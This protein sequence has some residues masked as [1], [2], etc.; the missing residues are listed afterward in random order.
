MAGETLSIVIPAWKST[1][2]EASLKSLATQ[3]DLRFRVYVGDDAGSVDIKHIAERFSGQLDLM[4]H[5]YEERLGASSLVQQW[6]R[7]VRLSGESWVWLF[8]DDDVADPHCVARFFEVL[9]ETQASYDVYRFNSV[10]IDDNGH[11]TAVHPPHP[12]EESAPEFLYHTLTNQRTSPAPE[13]IFS[14]RIFDANEGFVDFPLAWS[15]D[16]ASYAKFSRKS[17]FRA[18]SGPVVRWRRSGQNISSR[19]DGFVATRKL[20]AVMDYCQWL[21]GFSASSGDGSHGIYVSED[22]L[23]TA[24]RR[25]ALRQWRSYIGSCPPRR[26]RRDDVGVRCA[27]RLDRVDAAVLRARTVNSGST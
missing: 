17:G 1:Y 21:E 3:T 9:E 14:R 10:S 20:R 24:R 12:Q 8:S 25:W 23:A 2:L 6:N 16:H 22:L 18:I 27:H 7:C 11:L 13:Y 5:R 15:S 4:Y 19:H 26:G